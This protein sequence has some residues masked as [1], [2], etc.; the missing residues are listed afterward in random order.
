[1]LIDDG[2][3]ERSEGGW[4]LAGVSGTLPVPPTIQA[5]LGARIDRLPEDDRTLLTHVSV[6]GAL[7]H[8]ESMRELAPVALRPVVDRSLGELVRR[9][10][11]RPERAAFGDDDAFRFRHIL[12]RDAAYRSLPKA[13][14]A[15]LHERFGGWLEEA[16]AGRARR[17]RGDRGLPPRAGVALPLGAGRR[18]RRHHRARRARRATG[19]SRP[20]GERCG[21]AITGPRQVSW[22]GPRG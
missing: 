10:L 5:L 22:S 7:F 9:D 1:M 15:E 14:R 21:V 3:L 6:E 18:G 17:V 4:A 16:H 20:A 12:I 8:R 2:L 13:T 11:I 19:S